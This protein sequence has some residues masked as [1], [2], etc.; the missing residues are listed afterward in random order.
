MANKLT[1]VAHLMC[2][3]DWSSRGKIIVASIDIAEGHVCSLLCANV[4]RFVVSLFVYITSE[5]S[6]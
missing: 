6:Q 5:R 3:L 1:L 2:C 4:S